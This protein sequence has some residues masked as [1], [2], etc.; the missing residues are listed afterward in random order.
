MSNTIRTVHRLLAHQASLA[1][2]EKAAADQIL[3][4]QEA[5]LAERNASMRT[6]FERCGDE[7][8]DGLAARH[9]W[10]LRMEMSRRGLENAA[11]EAQ[12]SSSRA[13]EAVVA[14]KRSARTIERFAERQEEHTTFALAQRSQRELDEIGSSSWWRREQR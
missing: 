9:T 4:Q 5:R 14:A 2:V 8:A 3:D 1:V 12:R 6:A 11:F 10:L 7:D 13:Q